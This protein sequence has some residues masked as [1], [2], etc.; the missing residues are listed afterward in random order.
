MLADVTMGD[1]QDA[2]CDLSNA[3]IVSWKMT[4]VFRRGC[5]FETKKGL[6]RGPILTPKMELRIETLPHVSRGKS[7]SCGHCFGLNFGPKTCAILQLNLRQESGPFLVG[8]RNV[9][10]FSWRCRSTGVPRG[11]I[12]DSLK[13]V[14]GQAQLSLTQPEIFN[15]GGTFKRNPF[16]ANF[17]TLQQGPAGVLFSRFLRPN[18]SKA[19][20]PQLAAPVLQQR[21]GILAIPQRTKLEIQKQERHPAAR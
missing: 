6:K 15:S 21:Y 13:L 19:A 12:C 7:P 20:A 4:Y 3:E 16:S 14:L 10:R 11:C 1:M 9:T 18:N 8:R 5:I 17:G 2:K